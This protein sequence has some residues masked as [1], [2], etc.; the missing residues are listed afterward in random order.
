MN[1]TSK[2]KGPL[3]LSRK[4]ATIGTVFRLEIEALRPFTIG[5]VGQLRVVAHHYA[6]CAPR[7]PECA[8]YS[9]AVGA[10]LIPG[11]NPSATPSVLIG[12]Q[13]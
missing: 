4:A 11:F 12:W 3:N 9:G 2:A 13:R 7:H 1:T 6:I 10:Q 8:K 5:P